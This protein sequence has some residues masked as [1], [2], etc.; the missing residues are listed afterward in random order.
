MEEA[1]GVVVA[2]AAEAQVETE[3]VR[4]AVILADQAEVT[5]EDHPLVIR[6]VVPE[7]IVVA[8]REEI[9]VVRPEEIAAVPRVEILED[10][11]EAI[12]VV[13]LVAILGG[14]LEVILAVVLAAT[15]A[16]E[17]WQ[18]SAAMSVLN[19]FVM[20]QQR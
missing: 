12:P 7:V 6:V 16:A 5:L 3:V 17:T 13:V 20:M 1:T 11:P 9:A 4:L 14:Q 19:W 18:K 8:L 10:Q 15:Q 2:M